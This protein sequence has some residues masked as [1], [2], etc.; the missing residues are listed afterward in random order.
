MR[1][2]EPGRRSG[3]YLNHMADASGSNAPG[4]CAE[5]PFGASSAADVAAEKDFLELPAAL[6][7]EE[8]V[9]DYEAAGLM[10]RS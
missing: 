10:L 6:E 3:S 1:R 8:V 7:G 2:S 9:R 5:E 4:G